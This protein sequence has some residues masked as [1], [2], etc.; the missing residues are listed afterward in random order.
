MEPIGCPEMFVMNNHFKPQ[1]SQSADL[2]EKNAAAELSLLV[3][4]QFK[5]LTWYDLSQ[6]CA[7]GRS[8]RS[9]SSG[10]TNLRLVVFFCT[11]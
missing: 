5:L 9:D 1:I 7:C 10:I 8:K 3:F 6:I 4:L 2:E 11:V